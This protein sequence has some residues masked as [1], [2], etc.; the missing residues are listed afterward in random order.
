MGSEPDRPAE[1]AKAEAMSDGA[2][3]RIT[4]VL[5]ITR[6]RLNLSHSTSS[7][8]RIRSHFMSAPRK[9][10]FSIAI[11]GVHHLK[12]SVLQIDDVA[13]QLP[14]HAAP[15]DDLDSIGDSR[16]LVEVVAGDQH[17]RPVLSRILHHVAWKHDAGGVEGVGGFIQDEQPG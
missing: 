17:R 9:Q 7:A 16:D 10:F 14:D 13:R 12:E 6:E 3:S 5:T 2:R 4:V 1:A 8:A 11:G 15:M